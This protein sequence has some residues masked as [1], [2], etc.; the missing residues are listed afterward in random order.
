MTEEEKE[1]T[2]QLAAHPNFRW[3]RGMREHRPD[4]SSSHY[5]VVIWVAEDGVAEVYDTAGGLSSSQPYTYPDIA[6]AATKGCLLVLARELWGVRGQNTDW[7]DGDEQDPEMWAWQRCDN[8]MFLAAPTEG[9]ALA[10][11]IMEAPKR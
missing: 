5:A 9:I 7:C 10:R 2:Q 8:R 3:M 6:D 4:Y 11:A 1:V